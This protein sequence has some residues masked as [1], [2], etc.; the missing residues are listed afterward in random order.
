[1]YLTQITRDF[2][3]WPDV[4]ALALEAF[5]PEEYLPPEKLVDM[6]RAD[7]FD[8]W[9]LMDEDRF[10]GFMVVQIH[11][12]MA[13]L[14]FLAIRSELR[15]LGYGA[16]ALALLRKNYPQYQQVVDLEM[17][18]SG[19]ANAAQRMIRKSFYLR[20]GYRETG[21]F[22][23]YLGVNYEVLCMDETFDTA[24][25]KALLAT[26]RVDGFHPVYFHLDTNGTRVEA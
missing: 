26:L 11:G 17:Q 22:L 15:S 7:S 3:F 14:F 19:A 24:A 10:V 13:Y 4:E 9:A 25:F 5:P 18:D 6:A 1:M 20:N 2:P 16:Q 8:F 23:T 12:R 21:L